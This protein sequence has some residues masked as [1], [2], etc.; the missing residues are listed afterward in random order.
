MF[1]EQYFEHWTNTEHVYRLAIE[2]EHPIFAFERTNFEHRT[3]AKRQF[4]IGTPCMFDVRSLFDCVWVWLMNMFSVGSMFEVLFDEH[5]TNIESKICQFFSLA[6]VTKLTPSVNETLIF[7]Q[8]NVIFKI[9][10]CRDP[11][12]K[13]KNQSIIKM[14]DEL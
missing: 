1:V 13:H 10:G 9:L 7:I 14:F 12:Y 8:V 6:L 4:S 3:W 11:I 2:L 5:L